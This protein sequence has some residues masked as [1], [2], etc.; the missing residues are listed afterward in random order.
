MTHQFKIP[1][2]D[3]SDDGHGMCDYYLITSNKSVEDVREIHFTIPEKLG[4]NIEEIC[5]DYEQSSISYE[6]AVQ[7]AEL[8]F[9]LGQIKE[10]SDVNMDSNSMCKLWIFL[11]MKADPT[12]ELK[13]AKENDVEMLP[14]Y[15]FDAKK[16]H[17]GFVGYGVFSN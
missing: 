9:D 13:I 10:D 16:R 14:F 15:G 11:L 12:L 4:V 8:G 2:G 1:I 6:T 5:S 3:W 7:I 17:I